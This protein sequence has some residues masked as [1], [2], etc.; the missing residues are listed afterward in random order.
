MR[1]ADFKILSFDCYGTLIDW[2]S[3]ILAALRPLLSRLGGKV[4]NDQALESFARHE[5]AIEAAEPALNYRKLLAKTYRALAQEWD[6]PVAEAEAE[7]FGDA[8]PDWPAFADSAPS[9]AYLKQ[10]YKLVILSNVDRASF[11][12]SNKKLG[13]VFDAICTAEDVGSYKPDRR[14]FEFMLR[15]VREKFGASPGDILHTAQSLFHD[16]QTAKAMGL[17]TN[18]I[19]GRAATAGAGATMPIEGISTDF[20]FTSMAALA[21]AHQKEQA[22]I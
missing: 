2:E 12:E 19:D 15:I 9:L 20:R 3:G 18:W 22:R 7:R 16:H 4:G 14:N 13:V 21:E 17:A 10:H 1:L 5:S 11:A 6:G 8:V